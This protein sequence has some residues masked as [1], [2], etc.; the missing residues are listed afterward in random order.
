MFLHKYA[1]TTVII[2]YKQK[3]GNSSA[4][5]F[6]CMCLSVVLQSLYGK[7]AGFQCRDVMIYAADNGLLRCERIVIAPQK[8][9]FCDTEG[10]VWRNEVVC[11]IR[12]FG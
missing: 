7:T 2:H 12:L 3:N 5:M 11:F 4:F 10:R 9:M 6:C 8:V 1:D